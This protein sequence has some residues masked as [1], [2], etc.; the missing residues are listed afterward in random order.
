LNPG[1]TPDKKSQALTGLAFL[2]RLLLIA[3]K[4][5][6]SYRAFLQLKLKQRLSSFQLVVQQI[7]HYVFTLF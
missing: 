7:M 3:R 6:L 5:A 4:K 2:L 1:S